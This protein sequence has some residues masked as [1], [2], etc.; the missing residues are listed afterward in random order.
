MQEERQGMVDQMRTKSEAVPYLQ[1]LKE[2][3]FEKPRIWQKIKA[4]ELSWQQHEEKWEWE[5]DMQVQ[6]QTAAVEAAA[7]EWSAQRCDA[8]TKGINAAELELQLGSSGLATES[9]GGD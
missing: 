7:V 3:A 1:K 2:L 6:Q 5:R 4:T 8:A 9:K